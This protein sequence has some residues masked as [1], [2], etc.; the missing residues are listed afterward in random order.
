LFRIDVIARPAANVQ[1]GEPDDASHQVRGSL[2]KIAAQLGATG[3]STMTAYKDDK[4]FADRLQAA[5]QAKKAALDKFR[6]Q[7]APDD[8]AVVERQAARA[9]VS[10]ARETRTAERKIT[11]EADAIRRKADA[12]REAAEKLTRDAEQKAGQEERA[13]ALKAEQKAARDSRYAAR[14]ARR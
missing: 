12:E 7:A 1:H 3:R 13:A 5:A 9:A 4:G 11:R 14:K 6:A 2:A 8:P 10:A